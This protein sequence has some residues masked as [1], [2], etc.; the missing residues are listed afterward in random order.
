MDSPNALDEHRKK[1]A[2]NLRSFTPDSRYPA[3]MPL[4]MND[5]RWY[6]L[7]EDVYPQVIR[8]GSVLLQLVMNLLDPIFRHHHHLQPISNLNLPLASP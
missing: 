8:I 7:N 5:M 1:Y 4:V 6:A 3:K 2:S